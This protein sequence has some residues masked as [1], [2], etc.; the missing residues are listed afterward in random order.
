MDAAGNRYSVIV[1]AIETDAVGGGP[2]LAA[3]WP[4]NVQVTNSNEPGKVE[5]KWLQPEVGTALPAMIDPDGNPN[6]TLPVVMADGHTTISEDNITGWQWYRAK[7]SNP[8]LDPNIGTLGGNASDWESISGATSTPYTPQGKTAAAGGAPATGLR[9]DEGWKLLVKADYTDGQGGSKSAIG[10]TDMPVRADVHDDQNN[11]PDFRQDTTARSVPEDTAV[12][13]DVGDVVDV[14]TNEDNDT[15][16]YTLDN[17]KDPA[18]PLDNPTAPDIVGTAAGN[19][20]DVAYFSIDKKTG[21]IRVAKPLDWD[22]NPAPDGCRRKI[23]G[24]GKGYGPFR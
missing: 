2:N 19:R 14:D 13:A 11:S 4:V 7:N 17:D 22:N 10:I 24:L 12:G 16:T 15:L 8:N 21:Q 9:L 6:A 20:G 18:T 1:R 5:V 3:E 23:C